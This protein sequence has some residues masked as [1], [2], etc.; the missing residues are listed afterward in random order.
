[1]LE[2]IGIPVAKCHNME[3]GVKSMQPTEA[4]ATFQ[5]CSSNSRAETKRQ[6]LLHRFTSTP[7]ATDLRLMQ[8]TVRLE[9]NRSA[10]LALTLD[11]FERH[12]DGRAGKPDFL[13]RIVCEPD[14]RVESTAVQLSAFSDLGLRY[15]NV[16]QR[17]FL[18]VDLE[19]REAMGALADLFVEG[20]P[21]LRYNRPFDILFCMTAPSLGLTALSGGCVGVEDRGVVVFG[22]PNS[23]KTTACY[24][25]AKQGMEFH[26]DQALFLDMSCNALRAWGDLFPAVFRPETLDFLPELRLSARRSTNGDL[27]FYYFDKRAL[28]ARQARPVVPVCSLF[29][30][31][32]TSCEPQLREIS[33][34][35]A[36]SRLR[37]CVLFSEDTRF[38]S[39]ITAALKALA[40]Q[41]V[42]SLRYGGSPK[43]AATFIEKLLA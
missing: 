39:Q 20:E 25:A 4:E 13:W 18:A 42:Y 10:V 16:G 7:Y 14:C 21:S 38:D 12:Q 24:L 27:S 40:E 36:L 37:D 6:D 2:Q 9:T 34:E 11:F 5:L 3:S 17:G 30:E 28:Q 31:R 23:G 26:A 35:D 22:P 1:M 33:Q 15:V 32:G 43:I 41:P 19:R 29:L 8:R